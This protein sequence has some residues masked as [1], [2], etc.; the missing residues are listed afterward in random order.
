MNAYKTDSIQP[1]GV[2]F[3]SKEHSASALAKESHDQD[4]LM[5]NPSLRQTVEKEKAEDTRLLES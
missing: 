2:A 4:H 5:L 1:I 3:G